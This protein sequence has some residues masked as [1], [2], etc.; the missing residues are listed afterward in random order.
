MF[1]GKSFSSACSL[2]NFLGE[3]LLANWMVNRSVSGAI[4]A[5]S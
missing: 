1:S 2:I 3:E 4:F 5:S